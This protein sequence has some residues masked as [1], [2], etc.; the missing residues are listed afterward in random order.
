MG[1]LDV[2]IYDFATISAGTSYYFISYFGEEILEI[3][4]AIGLVF[5]PTGSLE[6]VKGG[7]FF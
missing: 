3:G 4:G 1:E 7:P 5:L 2:N 6:A